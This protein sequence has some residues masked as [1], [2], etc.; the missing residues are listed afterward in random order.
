MRRS[1][2]CD[3]HRTAM[4]NSK[5]S[6]KMS[7]THSTMRQCKNDGHLTATHRHSQRDTDYIGARHRTP[8]CSP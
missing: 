6:Q 2:K 7:E 4:L 3:F 5:Q 1:A 8:H